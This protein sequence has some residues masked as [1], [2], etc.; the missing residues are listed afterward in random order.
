V[1]FQGRKRWLFV[2]IAGL[3]TLF[4]D[5]IIAYKIEATNQ[6]LQFMIGQDGEA[7]AWYASPDFWAVLMMG[8]VSTIVW[9]IV[10]ATLLEELS[11]TNY[12]QVVNLEIE[13]RRDKI[14]GI[15]EKIDSLKK[16]FGLMMSKV[17]QLK[18][19]IDRLSER[20]QN[21][22]VSLSELDNYAS[23]FYD[24]WIKLVGTLPNKQ[25]LLGLCEER[26]QDF[27]SRYLSE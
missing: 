1:E 5:G 11:K 23:R 17:S 14:T 24:G 12:E 18:I 3:F 15:R 10:V 26:Y 27:R 25:D 2:G 21:M 6:K 9:G 20:K 4:L 7:S 13:K 19:D 16:E 8:F 22:K